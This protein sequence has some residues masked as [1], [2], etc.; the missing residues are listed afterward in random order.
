MK[1][2]VRWSSSD[3]SDTYQSGGYVLSFGSWKS[4]TVIGLRSFNK[5]ACDSWN[6]SNNEVG[7]R[8]GPDSNCFMRSAMSSS[9][10]RFLATLIMSPSCR[11][12]L[13]SPVNRLLTSSVCDVKVGLD[14]S[15]WSGHV[16]R[17]GGSV[18]ELFLVA[19]SVCFRKE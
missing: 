14:F 12:R 11:G 17:V 9:I 8:T 7:G 3:R 1:Y 4:E 10:F 2:S 16:I 15:G 13:T 18:L 6:G 19:W 5:I